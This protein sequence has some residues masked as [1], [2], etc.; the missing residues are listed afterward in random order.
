MGVSGSGKTTI[1]KLL[2]DRL[3]CQ[4]YDADDFHPSNNIEKMSRGI[5][6]N[7]NDR[8][9]W[10]LKLNDIV[11]NAI[12]EGKSGVMACS[13]LKEQYRQIIGRNYPQKITWIY[14]RGDYATI[15]DRLEKRSNH[16]MPEDL[17]CSQ[18]DALEE[19]HNAINVDISFDENKL[20]EQITN[21]L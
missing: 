20:I 9:P 14:L 17:L 1:G 2:S 19:P 7:D 4:F 21:Q 11:S 16:F 8:L 15:R 13:A 18:F 6:L 5:P 3:N 12:K 10:L